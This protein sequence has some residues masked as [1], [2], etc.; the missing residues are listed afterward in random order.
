MNRGRNRAVTDKPSST[1]NKAKA[2]DQGMS[3]R[4]KGNDW[5]FGMKAHVGVDLDSSVAHSLDTSTAK[6][7]ESQVWDELLHGEEG[8]VWADKGTKR[9][10]GAEPSLP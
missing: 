4:K 9:G 10:P 8:S 6:V 1:K 3:S 7:H 2:P 5:Y